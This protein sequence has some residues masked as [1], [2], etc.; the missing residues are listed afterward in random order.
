MFTIEEARELLTKAD[1]FFGYD[2]EDDDPTYA[3]TI[4]LNDA[5]YWAC[6]DSEYVEDN[7]L[8]RV[9]QLFYRYGWCGV[10]YW[11]AIEKRGGETPE[12]LDVKRKIEFVKKEE[13]LIKQESS[14]SK[15]AYAKYSYT[16]G[17]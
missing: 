4:N 16:L 8:V 6:S 1:I 2:D 9:A 12:F 3:Q 14:R 7:E 11:V 13:E 5:M 15:R 17:E 10:L